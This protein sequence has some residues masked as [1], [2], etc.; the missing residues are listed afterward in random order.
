MKIKYDVYKGILLTKQQ[1]HAFIQD[2]LLL[3]YAQQHGNSAVINHIAQ[4]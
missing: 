1:T 2:L 4:Q 3:Q